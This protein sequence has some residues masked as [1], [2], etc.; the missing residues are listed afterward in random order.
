M[1]ALLRYGLSKN[2]PVSRD[3]PTTPEL[4]RSYDVVIIGGGGHGLAIA[5]YLAKRWNI[6]RVAVIESGYLAGGN[7]ARNTMGVR[8]TYLSHAS[9]AFYKE[10]VE[11][12]RDLSRELRFNV[13]VARRGQISLA[14]RAA[15]VSDFYRRAA[16]G[17][18]L[19]AQTEVIEDRA[20]IQRL[21]PQID[22][23]A[24]GP[25]L[26]ALWHEDYSMVRHD[27]VAWGFAARGSALGVEIHQRT[28]VTGFEIVADRVVAVQTNRGRIS[29]GQVVQAC[30]GMNSV[31]AAMAGITLPIRT[32]PLQAMVTTPVKPIFDVTFIA[33]DLNMAVRQTARGEI[34]LGATTLNPYPSYSTRSTL[35]MKEKVVRQALEMCPFLGSLR[36]MRQWTG[37]CDM[38][39][40]HSPILGG[41]PLTNYWL[42]VGWGTGGFKSI[43]AAG[44]RLAETVATGLVPDILLPFRLERF[45]TF[46]LI[47]EMVAFGARS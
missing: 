43:V 29:A 20:R 16:M 28:E 37:I 24:A 18:L 46:D 9:V 4:K 36:L 45:S 34:V 15:T 11:A 3:V 1:F 40:D 6:R 8:S 13:Q 19:G 32:I 38:T 23:D 39:A 26:A 5:Y 7:T 31:V 35:D 27:A 10:C 44:Q 12:Y 14:H 42:D 33:A 25:V 41:S 21:C 2:Y 17:K 30:G 47:D 22:I